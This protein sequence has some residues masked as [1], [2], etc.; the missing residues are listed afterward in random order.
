ML[1]KICDDINRTARKRKWDDKRYLEKQ[2]RER[3]ERDMR[4][5]LKEEKEN[6]VFIVNRRGII[7]IVRIKGE[8]ENEI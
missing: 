8:E 7:R 5:R 2:K 3:E 1:C 4:E 6:R